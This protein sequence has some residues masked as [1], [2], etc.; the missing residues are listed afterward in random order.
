M[1]FGQIRAGAACARAE[2]APRASFPPGKRPAGSGLRGRAELRRSFSSRE[3]RSM[4]RRGF[5]LVELLVVVAI[6]GLLVALLIPAVQ[7]S[8]ASARRASCWNNLRQIGIATHLFANN[9][10]GRF[11]QT[12]H[13]G[14][15]QSWVYT[16]SRFVEDVEAI[17]FCPDHE[18]GRQW[19]LEG[20]KGTSYVIN[21]FVAVKLPE[22]VLNLHKMKETSKTII[23][24]EISDRLRAT[25][26]H[27]HPSTWYLP[28]LIKKHIVWETI[29]GEIHPA[30]HQETSN[31]LYADSHVETI[32]ETIVYEWVQQDIAKGTNFAQPL[33]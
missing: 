13:A 14:P 7:A 23:Q 32:A 28:I 1:L 17:R 6:T 10:G 27:C 22:S 9:N 26:E 8:R 16:L 19:L 15:D 25:D 24:F 33:K 2:L 4:R 30:R 12:T 18:Q 3:I 31:Y 20:K 21:E 5:T 11:P 29:T